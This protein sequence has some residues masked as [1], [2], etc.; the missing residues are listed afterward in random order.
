MS[1]PAAA[2]YSADDDYRYGFNGM[3]KDKSFDSE[4]CLKKM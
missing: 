2:T 1:Y 4:V 3:E